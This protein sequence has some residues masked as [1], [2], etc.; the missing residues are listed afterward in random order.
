MQTRFLLGPAGSGKTFRCLQE[1]RAALQH[2]P[3]GPP[4]VLIAP[5]QATFQL[6]RQLLADESLPGYTRLQILSFDRLAQFILE[7]LNQSTGNSLSEEGR[8]MVLRAL[9]L[10][11]KEKLKMFRASA[12]MPG[13]AQQLSLLLR[14]FQRH[15]LPPETL[16]K[17][18]AE[19]K[20]PLSGKLQDVAFLLDLYRAWLEENHLRDADSLLDLATEALRGDIAGEIRIPGLWLDG[21]A[22]MTPQELAL[23][24]ALIPRCE[25]ATLAFCLDE[26][27]GEKPSSLSIWSVVHRIF[28]ECRA[29][30]DQLPDCTIQVERLDRDN[31][32]SRFAD[33]PALRHL[34]EHWTRPQPL[35]EDVQ[36]SI[37]LASCANPEEEAILAAKE[38][39]RFVRNGGRFRNVA[40]LLRQF[41]G[42]HD[43]LRRTFSRYEIPFFLDRRESIAHHPLAELT[44]SA[45]RLAAYGWEHDDFFCG[46]KTG[47][48]TE[49]E[50]SIDQLENEALARGWK[51]EAWLGPLQFSEESQPLPHLERL[52]EK[53]VPSFQKFTNA[54]AAQ[55][56]SLNGAQLASAIRALWS[57]L[58]VEATLEKWAETNPAHAT[59]WD[60]MQSWLE[61]ITTGFS[62]ESLRLKDWLPILEAGLSGLT[63]GA[64]PPALD[65]VLIGTIDRS[66]N[67]D[68]R[69]TLVLGLNES[70][71]PA[72]PKPKSL[73]TESD[74]AELLKHDVY[75][76]PTRLEL[77]GRER[78]YGY[79]ACTRS[80]ERLVLTC[81]AQDA[82]GRAQNPSPF[83]ALIS[84]LF[85][86]LEHEKFLAEQV[87]FEREHA[88]ELMAPLIQSRIEARV[89]DPLSS[90]IATPQFESVRESIEHFASWTNAE[91]LSREMAERLYGSTLKTSV[92][93]LEQFAACPFRFFV[94]AGLRAQERRV[95]EVD[96]RERGSFQHAI[97]ATFHEQLHA[98]GKRWRDISP[99]EARSR[100]QKIGAELKNTFHNGLFR[101]DAQSDFSAGGMIESLQDFVEVTID[102][103]AQY[104]FDPQVVEM[105]FGIGEKALPAWELDLEDGHKLAFRGFIDRV[106]ICRLPD[107]DE[108]MAIVVDYKSSAKH[109]DPVFLEH[110]IQLQLPAYLALLRRIPDAERIFGAKRLVPAGVFYI[111]LRGDFSGGKTREDV[112]S[113]REEARR[114]AFQH[115]GRFNF[116]ALRKLDNRG[117]SA[118]TQFNYRLTKKGEPHGACKEILRTEDFERLLDEAERHLVRMGKEI[119]DGVVKINPY[120][121]GKERACEKCDYVTICRID[122]WTHSYRVLKK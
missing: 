93:A 56:F 103:M 110:G 38:I 33:S 83:L 2:S 42:Y 12:R 17:L 31:K 101:A 26:T 8:V 90:L 76:G 40:V 92:S 120:Q 13:F 66:R 23:L 121:K 5:K 100:I 35:N 77:L 118:G 7:K 34:E 60:Q 70:V 88:S 80:T 58:A 21:F 113:G 115:V 71:F 24:T 112:L 22:E 41:D 52:R 9:L 97:L 81:A 106:D 29:R 73:L 32:R 84:Q 20:T 45:L 99:S 79:I 51:K 48:V 53:I 75:L 64:I 57:D 37:R 1:I 50:T 122:P 61:N 11:N 47:L 119:F 98:E 19:I 63:V 10:Q 69:L 82:R 43:A 74:Q 109:L 107:S 14:E 15:Q 108:A 72:A 6:E 116:A 104:E 102:W 89:D 25:R 67:P 62:G 96:V 3:D 55:K 94:S 85:P 105:G 16:R 111:N 78:F 30:F 18:S 87:W 4:L 95:F 68:L 54:I 86:K 44:R 27:D 39:L 59:V 36:K 49:D 117:V 91:S 114:M 28:L 65:Q 46:L